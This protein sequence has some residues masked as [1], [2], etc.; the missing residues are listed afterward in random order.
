MGGTGDGEELLED[1]GERLSSLR[2]ELSSFFKSE[3][4]RDDDCSEDD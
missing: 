2:L 1:A 4:D 3:Q